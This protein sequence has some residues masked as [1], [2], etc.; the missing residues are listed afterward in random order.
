VTPRATA[1]G[2]RRPTRTTTPAWTGIAVAKDP[3]KV[4]PSDPLAREI[5]RE[6][7][8]TSP[9]VLTARFADGA[10]H[11]VPVRR[12]PF[13]TGTV[14][15]SLEL[16]YQGDMIV[17]HA[18]TGDWEVLG[19]EFRQLAERGRLDNPEVSA[20]VGACCR[21]ARQEAGL[22]QVE[23]AAL[24]GI[25]APNIS[26]IERGRTPPRLTTLERLAAAYGTTIADLLRAEA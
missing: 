24:T 18:A 12:L 25:A 16:R 26:R 20:R 4:E 22:T 8:L 1:R 19:D 5:V 21:L 13:R 23:A 6:A 17:V 9:R 11:S 14:V 3:Y 7:W 2:A 15:D 10:V